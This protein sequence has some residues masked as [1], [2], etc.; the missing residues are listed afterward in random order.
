[1]ERDLST[2]NQNLKV[3]FLGTGTSQ[4]IP[5]IACECEVCQSVDYR[6]QRLRSSVLIESDQTKFVIDTG[7]DFRQQMLS[8]RVHCLDAVVFTHEHKDHVAGLDDIR[9]YNF[10]QKRD[11]PIYAVDRVI[12][13]LKAEFS[14]IFADEKYPGVPTV[15][16]NTLENEKFNIGDIEVLP[17]EVMHY[18]LPVMGFRVK[19]FAYIT[20]AKTI[21]DEE[22][23][24]LKNLDTLV[25]NALQIKEHISHL[26]LE[27]ALSWI[28][29][30]Q[31][32]KAY[33]THISHYL[34]LHKEVE[35]T[36]PD[37]VHLSY[38][39]LTLTI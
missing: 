36:I 5:V 8:N 7:P 12:E 25:L 33:L 3:T 23:D 32:K 13:R 10:K 29:E 21:T 31:P 9:S 22:K 16:V 20:D 14:Y 37:N 39:G 28:D 6:N 2:P 35:K 1:M 15:E 30:L 4:G 26:T 24:K 11:M 19:D 38:D 17:I 27:E 34:G 18:K